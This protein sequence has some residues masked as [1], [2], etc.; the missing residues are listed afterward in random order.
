VYRN[1]STPGKLRFTE[2]GLASGVARDDRGTPTGSMGV[3]VADETGSGRPS[4]FVTCYES[5]F[6]SLFRSRGRGLFV[7][8]TPVAGI[9]KIGQMF[10]GFGTAFFDLDNDDWDDLF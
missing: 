1:E 10:V 2:V 3:D 5:E 6:H 7:F 4:L 8:S 9:G